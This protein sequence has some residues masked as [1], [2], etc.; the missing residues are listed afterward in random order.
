MKIS[1]IALNALR[2]L[3]HC[4]PGQGDQGEQGGGHQD[5]QQEP[6]HQVSGGSSRKLF[7]AKN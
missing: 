5:L 2:V 6:H 4:L 3:L 7:L 1:K